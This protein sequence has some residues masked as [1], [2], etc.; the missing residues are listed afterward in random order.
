[1]SDQALL[2]SILAGVDSDSDGTDANSDSDADAAHVP[3]QKTRHSAEDWA[4]QPASKRAKIVP[5]P[6]STPIGSAS[7]K[8]PPPPTLPPSENVAKVPP[9]PL[10]PLASAE[11][12]ERAHNK[13]EEQVERARIEEEDRVERARIE[14]EERVERAR[15]EE[16]A[17]VERARIEEEERLAKEMKKRL[18]AKASKSHLTTSL[19]FFKIR[20]LLQPSTFRSAVGAKYVSS[21]QYKQCNTCFV[22]AGFVRRALMPRSGVPGKRSCAL[23]QKRRPALQKKKKKR[24]L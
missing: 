3:S 7:S 17:R 4:A 23:Q 2:Q 6:H 11:P 19:A 15:I 8:T 5:T 22:Y 16:E 10:P 14:E 12:V 1:M 9:P 20:C 21:P 13:E 18:A 24:G